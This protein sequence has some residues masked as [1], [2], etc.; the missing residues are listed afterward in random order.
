MDGEREGKKK[1]S[2]LTLRRTSDSAYVNTASR[3]VR[4]QATLCVHNRA[5]SA[6]GKCFSNRTECPYSWAHWEGLHNSTNGATQTIYQVKKSQCKIL[7]WVEEIKF[8]KQL[9][10]FTLS[11]CPNAKLLPVDDQSPS[12]HLINGTCCSFR[13]NVHGRLP[14]APG[15]TFSRDTCERVGG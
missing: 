12:L 9:D 3:E 1:G 2:P 7:F 11:I 13:C 4:P 15:G 5:L 10:D 8:N 14:F 6:S